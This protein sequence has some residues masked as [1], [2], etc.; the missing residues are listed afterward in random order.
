MVFASA[1]MLFLYYILN[2]F[3]SKLAYKYLMSAHR[4]Y[5]TSFLD[6]LVK[7]NLDN[8]SW[9]C[10]RFFSYENPN[11]KDWTELRSLVLKNPIVNNGKIEKGVFLVKFST[12]LP[13][14]IRDLD[15]DALLQWFWLVIEPSSSNYCA[16]ELLH[17]ARYKNSPIIIQSSEVADLTF[18]NSMNSNLKPVSYGSSDWVDERIFSP[19]DSK[20][21]YDA[22]F[23]ASYNVVKRHHRFFKAVR[24]LKKHG[25]RAAMVCTPYGEWKNDV[26]NLLKYYGVIKHVDVYEGL[27]PTALARLMERSKVNVLLSLKEGSNRAIFEGFFSGTPGIVLR[28]NIGVNKSYINRETGRLIYDYELE[29][30]LLEFM[31][32]THQY[33]PREWALQNISPKVTTQ[34][35]N[36]HLQALAKAAGEDWTTDIAVKVNS[37]EATY[38]DKSDSE[39]LLTVSRVKLAFSRTSL[40][41]DDRRSD[42]LR[43]S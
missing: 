21:D 15:C 27:S 42:I 25:F 36:R 34:K 43:L 20:K 4:Y 2:F 12:T 39:R 6:E 14:V 1:L 38:Y 33:V 16:P 29:S 17:W 23:V 31:Q 35:L 40:L 30:T 28:E 5:R 8:I 26:Y 13:F 10:E 22:I 37:P 7:K 19:T 18:I 24:H 3:G 41:T 11:D 9:S 32:E